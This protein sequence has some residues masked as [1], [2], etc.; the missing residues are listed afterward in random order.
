MST[1]KS[2]RNLKNWRL[3]NYRRLTQTLSLLLFFYLLYLIRFPWDVDYKPT[4]YLRFDL[5]VNLFGLIV[6]I[7]IITGGIFI[8]IL[9]VSLIFNRN[10]C[11]WIC[12]VGAL[13]DGFRR[14]FVKPLRGGWVPLNKRAYGWKFILF[15]AFVILALA[16]IPLLWLWEPMSLLPRSTTTVFFPPFNAG[17]IAIATF[18]RE[19]SFLT[20]L[21]R[22]INNSVLDPWQPHYLHAFLMLIIFAIPFAIEFRHSRGFCRLL[23]PLG[24]LMGYLSPFI[25]TKRLVGSE[26]I[27]CIACQKDCRMGAIYN[28]GKDYNPGECVLCGDCIDICPTSAVSFNL[29]PKFD[30]K[31][32][33]AMTESNVEPKWDG[34][35]FSLSRR[36]F[37]ASLGVGIISIPIIRCANGAS[38]RP[39]NHLRPPGSVPE[40][41]FMKRCLK[42]AACIKVCPTHGL[43]PSLMETGLAGLFSPHLVPMLGECEFTCNS[44]GLVC[45]SGAIEPIDIEEKAYVPIGIA[46]F[47][48]DLCIPTALGDPCQVCEEFCPTSP[49]S[50]L[51]RDE[52]VLNA[53]MEE[54]V[55]PVP[56]IVEETCIGCGI[57]ERVCP[58]I[59]SPAVRCIYRGE[60]RGRK[61]IEEYKEFR[62]EWDANRKDIENVYGDTEWRSPY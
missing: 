38:I 10:L 16:G 53:D 23:C 61:A 31:L 56:Y 26:C 44:C 33:H 21:G 30:H 41:E 50:I 15:N 11:G 51:M 29:K 4:Q 3:S 39:D 9:L 35:R 17:L 18:L 20:S 37:V 36:A 2:K 46:Y 5:L 28:S 57:C 54:V 60:A 49:K 24:A 32:H 19:H 12:P 55:V 58:V 6:G 42:C 47:K 1:R 40:D 34:G 13:L 45:P 25:W 59:E 27:E 43:Q 48:R 52:T 22:F 14:L 62:E 8:V 7:G